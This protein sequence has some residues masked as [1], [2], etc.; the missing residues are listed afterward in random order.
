MYININKN[1]IIM[2][3]TDIDEYDINTVWIL[4]P[5]YDNSKNHILKY[6]DPSS[7]KFEFIKRRTK[8]K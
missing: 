6:I 5:D 4:N 3:E 8:T 1:Q 7:I 2:R